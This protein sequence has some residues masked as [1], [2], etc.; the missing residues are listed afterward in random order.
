MFNHN[1]QSPPRDN[2]SS[3]ARSCNP[4]LRHR[5]Y[6]DSLWARRRPKTV[7]DAAPRKDFRGS[8]AVEDDCAKRVVY[9]DA[10]D[11]KRNAMP[12]M[13]TPMATLM[14]RRLRCA[15][16]GGKCSRKPRNSS[17]NPVTGSE[18]RVTGS[19]S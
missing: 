17:R 8:E 11:G 19:A 1:Y 4:D 13:P 16:L 10:K 5:R 7:N 3:V 18:K 6:E 2:V 9:E 14:L 15:Y 12:V